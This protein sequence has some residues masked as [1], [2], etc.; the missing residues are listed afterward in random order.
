[1]TRSFAYIALDAALRGVSVDVTMS[2]ISE[3]S[4]HEERAYSDLVIPSIASGQY[5][6]VSRSFEHKRCVK[7]SFS[8]GGDGFQGV[9]D[10]GYELYGG[11]TIGYTL[12]CHPTLLCTMIGAY[13][14]SQNAALCPVGIAGPRTVKRAFEG[15]VRMLRRCLRRNGAAIALQRAWRARRENAES[16]R[17]RMRVARSPPPSP[18]RVSLVIAVDEESNEWCD[19]FQVGRALSEAAVKA[20]SASDIDLR[21]I[22]ARLRG[23][24]LRTVESLAFLTDHQRGYKLQVWE[25]VGDDGL[26]ILVAATA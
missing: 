24:S 19:M 6:H 17:K 18:P 13:D 4:S 1:M 22:Q 9:T 26:P 20:A 21:D 15:L 3:Y 8:E 25:V 23:V 14:S 16:S 7:F 11:L 10:D 12:E 2:R 5:M